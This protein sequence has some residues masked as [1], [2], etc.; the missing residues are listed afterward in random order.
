MSN[1]SLS[2][3]AVYTAINLCWE[4][5]NHLLKVGKYTFW[6]IKLEWFE[7]FTPLRST[8]IC[9]ASTIPP[10]AMVPMKLPSLREYSF[11]TH[12]SFDVK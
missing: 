9:N 7:L 6:Q 2:E 10:M 11:P 3:H 12:V 8:Q 4:L 1:F 5:K